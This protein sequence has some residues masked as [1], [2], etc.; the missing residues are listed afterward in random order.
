MID[1][2]STIQPWRPAA[3]SDCRIAMQLYG[4]HKSFYLYSI[5]TSVG[6]TVQKPRKPSWRKSKRA[7]AVRVRRPL[8]KI[9]IYSKS[10]IY[11]AIANWGLILT[12]AVLLTVCTILSRIGHFRLLYSDCGH[13]RNAHQYQSNHSI[14]RCK[15]HLLSYKFVTDNMGLS[16][17][18]CCRPNLWN[19]AIEILRKFELI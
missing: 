15:V 7:T 2:W 14:H 3:P 6:A 13:Q 12:V 5:H 8:K 17:S 4:I 18:R 10:T 1:V 16:F 11:S 9:S 19:D